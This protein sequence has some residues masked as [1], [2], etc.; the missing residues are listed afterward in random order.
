MAPPRSPNGRVLQVNVSAGGVPKLPVAEAHVGTLGL[1]G[2]GQR[3]AT[4]HGGP[5]RAVCLLGIE[6]ISRVAAEGH[7]IA[8]G[9]TGENLTTE[10][11]DV[12]A[13]PP[14][15]RLEIGD[16]LILELSD[17]AGPCRTIRHSF[18]DLR[19]G[20][21]SVA[22]HPRDSRMYARV[23][24]EGAVRPGDAI[25]LYPPTDDAAQ[26]HLVQSRLDAAER[27]STLPL[28]RAAARAGMGVEFIDDGEIAVAAAPGLPGP[29]FNSGHGFANLPNLVD[30]ALDHFSAHGVTGWVVADDAPW[31]GAEAETTY[32]RFAATPAGVADHDVATNVRVRELPRDDVGTFAP[33]MAEGGG[34]TGALA[35]AF[36]RLER[37]VALDAHFHRFLADVD[38]RPAGVASL[39]TH[40]RVGWLRGA[41]VLP[42]MRGTGVHRALIRARAERARRLGCEL[43]GSSAAEGSVSARNLE[44]CGLRAIGT[45]RSYR[46]VP[47]EG[48]ST[49]S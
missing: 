7:P 8:P 16:D 20:R 37:D 44:A 47:G 30:V 48:R 22:T 32:A 29:I 43:I 17:D 18:R 13:L 2:D 1:V 14:G 10:G 40:H 25:R 23:V 11:F 27:E 46:F 35:D 42:A 9:T 28:W 41:T 39:R 33:L 38:G 24:R 26:R 21:L 15:T 6:A 19:F 4:V 45:R 12:S 31:P 49:V 3:E 36:I 34:M 5:H